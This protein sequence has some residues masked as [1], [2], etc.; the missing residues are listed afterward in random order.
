MTNNFDFILDSMVYSFS[1]ASTY[2][3]CAHGFNLT[4]ISA[5]DRAANFFSD[6]GLLCHS[7]LEEYFKGELTIE[8][9][10]QYYMD[11]WTEFV[12]SPCPPYPQGMEENYY[13]QGLSFFENFKFNK[14]D[15]EVIFIEEKIDANYHGINLVVKPDLILKEK[16]TGKFILIDYKTAKIK[17]TK[18]LKEKQIEGYLKQFLLYANFLWWERDVKIDE[19]QIWFLRDQKVEIIP[20]DP[21]KI[22]DVLTWFEET[23]DAIRNEEEWKPNLSK[24]NEYFC[25]QICS[26]RAYCSYRN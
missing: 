17:G 23:I 1:S 13:R 26:V 2:D 20:V 11:N 3:T 14:D 22:G 5:E 25:S 7:V 19:I 24:E 12:K 8:E 10:P 9:L 16:S 15:Y 18:A 4:Y 6:F 21:Y